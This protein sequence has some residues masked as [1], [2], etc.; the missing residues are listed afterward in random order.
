MEP[1]QNQYP[2]DSANPLTT[3]HPQEKNFT[4]VT[5]TQQSPCNN[6]EKKTSPTSLI[7]QTTDEPVDLIPKLDIMDPTLLYGLSK[8]HN[9]ILFW[10]AYYNGRASE[11]PIKKKKATKG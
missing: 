6:L 10:V 3:D 1:N 4:L 2:Q 9:N 8:A 5:I 7:S 11:G